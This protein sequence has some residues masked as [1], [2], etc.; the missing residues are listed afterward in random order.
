VASLFNPRPISSNPHRE[1]RT[2]QNQ[3]PLQ[4]TRTGSLPDGR[5]HTPA[6]E[7]LRRSRS[8]ATIR[9][10]NSPPDPPKPEI[11]RMEPP[12]RRTG[13]SHSA[14]YGKSKSN[15][16]SHRPKSP[17]IRPGPRTPVGREGG[18][19]DRGCSHRTRLLL[20]LSR[21]M[22]LSPLDLCFIWCTYD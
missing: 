17:S 10:G 13:L 19:L 2:R 3:Q 16:S 21:W 4:G 11:R 15:T 22:R 1:T 7:V 9:N 6:F 8:G 5:R 14:V 18:A 12:G 20:R